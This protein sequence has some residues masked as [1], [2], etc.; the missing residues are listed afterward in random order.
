[1]VAK[2]NRALAVGSSLKKLEVDHFIPR[3]EKRYVVQGRNIRERQPLLGN[4][5]LVAVT[6]CWREVL[7]LRDVHGMLM[8]ECGFPAQVLPCELAQLRAICPDG[9]YGGREHLTDGF[10]YGAKVLA[11]KGPLTR[12]TGRYIG[13]FG[14]NREEALF[15]LFGREQKVVFKRGELILA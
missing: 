8:N 14:K 10:V 4:Y 13:R 9:V 7:R 2:Q 5:V 3:V 11:V 6:Q 15:S 12:L 1:M